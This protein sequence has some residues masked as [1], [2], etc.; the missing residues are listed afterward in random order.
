M[1]TK[2]VQE[3]LPVAVILSPMVKGR[4]AGLR[5]GQDNSRAE[6]TRA[7]LVLLSWGNTHILVVPGKFNQDQ[8]LCWT[9]SKARRRTRVAESASV[10]GRNKKYKRD[11]PN[12]T[13][14]QCENGSVPAKWKFPPDN[15]VYAS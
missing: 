6:S 8:T 2:K 3:V 14:N 4:E 7:L 15:E 12:G 1:I 5:A 9:P 10:W 13:I 11:H